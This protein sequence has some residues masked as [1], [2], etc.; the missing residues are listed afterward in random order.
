MKNENDPN[1]YQ[2]LMSSLSTSEIMDLLIRYLSHK[3]ALDIAEWSLF[4]KEALSR[5]T[6]AIKKPKLK[7]A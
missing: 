1:D 4:L 2:K 6:K 7:V 3:G 5:E